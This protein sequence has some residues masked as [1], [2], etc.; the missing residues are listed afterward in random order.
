MD[1]VNLLTQEKALSFLNKLGLENGL[2]KLQQNPCKFITDL[3]KAYQEHVPF[4]V[5]PF[6]SWYDVRS[7]KMVILIVII[8]VTVLIKMMVC[9]SVN[10]IYVSLSVLICATRML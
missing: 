10:Y 9:V 8:M 6:V 3:I 4:Q 1:N 7:S 5:S 2:E